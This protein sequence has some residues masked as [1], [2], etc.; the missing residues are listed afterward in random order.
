MWVLTV[1]RMVGTWEDSYRATTRIRFIQ[2]LHKV[3][4]HGSVREC[5]S[6]RGLKIFRVKITLLWRYCPF[7]LPNG[8]HT[9][10]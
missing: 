4:N 9:L 8:N 1:Y 5:L 7:Q 10:A 2:C 3:I 6:V